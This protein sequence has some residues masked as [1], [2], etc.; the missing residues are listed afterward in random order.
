[1]LHELED[2]GSDRMSVCGHGE[3]RHDTHNGLVRCWDVLGSGEVKTIC[4]E[5]WEEAEERRGEVA[6]F[7][8]VGE[9]VYGE[10]R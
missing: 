10:G 4:V 7:T 6:C 8:K 5:D 3:T 2:V 9:A 1:M